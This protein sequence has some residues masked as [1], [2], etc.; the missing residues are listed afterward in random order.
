MK[1]KGFTLIAVLLLSMLLSLT[2][3]AQSGWKT[4]GN[5][6]YYYNEDGTMQKGWL[7]VG[8]NRY[9]FHRKTGVMFTGIRKIQGMTYVFGED[10]VL[11]KVYPKAGFKKTASG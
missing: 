9:Y 7:T 5:Q 10:G 3:F 6:K 4:E 8:E 1:K 11:Q 2:A